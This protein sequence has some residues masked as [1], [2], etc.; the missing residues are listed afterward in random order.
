MSLLN[1]NKGF[2]TEYSMSTASEDMAEVFSFL[3]ISKK[4]IE[5]KASMDPILNKKIFFIK[6]NILKID[7]NFSFN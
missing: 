2:V 6:K 3:M 7:E 1:E 4:M 5:K